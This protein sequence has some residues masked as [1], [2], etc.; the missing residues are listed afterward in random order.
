M[1]TFPSTGIELIFSQCSKHEEGIRAKLLISTSKVLPL[2]FLPINF[3]NVNKNNGS[4][5]FSSNNTGL[6]CPFIQFFN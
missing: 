5:L 6:N 1:I 3:N 4:C 2:A